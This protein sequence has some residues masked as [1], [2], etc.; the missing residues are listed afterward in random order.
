MS[1]SQRTI[2]LYS[3]M[4]SDLITVLTHTSYIQNPHFIFKLNYKLMFWEPACIL[5]IILQQQNQR[6]LE[7]LLIANKIDFVKVDGADAEMKDKRNALFGVS[8]IRGKYPQC[9]FEQDNGSVEFVGTWEDI[10]VT[11]VP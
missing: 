11:A 2:L 9:F 3:S 1:N 8:S 4:A 5:P 6:R 7:D 10:E